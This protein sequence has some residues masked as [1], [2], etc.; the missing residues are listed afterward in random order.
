M[1][2]LYISSDA[3]GDPFSAQGLQNIEE[4][5]I[6]EL[7][8]VADKVH[9]EK[10]HPDIPGLMVGQLGGP[11][12]ELVQLIAKAMKQTGEVLVKGGYPNLGAFVLEALK[13]GERAK[14]DTKTQ[15][16]INPECDVILERV[17]FPSLYVVNCAEI[18][19]SI[20]CTSVPYTPGYGL[21]RW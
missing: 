16:L 6:A 2:G 3:E 13:E 20:A 12:W 11:V 21:G 18:L 7:M 10:P 8:G 4:G 15:D 17:S 14:S 1:F 9:Q 5:K 19:L